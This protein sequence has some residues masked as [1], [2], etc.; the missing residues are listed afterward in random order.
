MPLQPG[1]TALLYSSYEPGGPLRLHLQITIVEGLPARSDIPQYSNRCS[2][3]R[4]RGDIPWVLIRDS[5]KVA[6]A[7]F[8]F[9]WRGEHDCEHENQ[10]L[11]SDRAS[12]VAH[13]ERAAFVNTRRIGSRRSDIECVSIYN[14]TKHQ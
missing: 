7:F 13:N 12:Q 8:L 11:L 6:L 9:A 4:N 2:T 5:P 3:G 10:F 14:N 1:G